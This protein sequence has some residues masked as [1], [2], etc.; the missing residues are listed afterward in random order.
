MYPLCKRVMTT[1]RKYSYNNKGKKHTIIALR[2]QRQPLQACLRVVHPPNKSLTNNTL[3]HT[4]TIITI[5]Q[6]SNRAV[7]YGCD[8][9]ENT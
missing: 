1:K 6:Q 3:R 7:A 9:S 5:S 8:F 2:D 4:S